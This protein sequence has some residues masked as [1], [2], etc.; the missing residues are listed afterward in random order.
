MSG[1]KGN[2]G[3]AHKKRKQ[4]SQNTHN[5]PTDIPQTPLPRRL[6]SANSG[7]EVAALQSATTPTGMGLTTIPEGNSAT[8][9]TPRGGEGTTQ[10]RQLQPSPAQRSADRNI[11][12]QQL[13]QAQLDDSDKAKD[14]AALD[15]TRIV[16]F[17]KI[18]DLDLD[19]EDDERTLRAKQIELLESK[20]LTAEIRSRREA[21]AHS[22]LER[23]H[24][25]QT[26]L[27]MRQLNATTES[28]H[29]K[30]PQNLTMKSAN[31]QDMAMV[32]A[33]LHKLNGESE[34]DRVNFLKQGAGDILLTREQEQMTWPK[35][36]HSVLKGM[37]QDYLQNLHELIIAPKS[38]A[39]MTMSDFMNLK[40]AASTAVTTYQWLLR[41]G[42]ESATGDADKMTARMIL[43]SLPE[44][45]RSQAKMQLAGRTDK[46]H[47]IAIITSC[48]PAT[49]GWLP[50]S[51]HYL[52]REKKKTYRLNV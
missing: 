40:H 38:R 44:D 2:N 19:E 29:Q 30:V 12:A 24:R 49:S 31:C 1:K 43:Y 35:L 33:H 11:E 32:A 22:T 7:G 6:R 9:T 39:R 10:Q 45:I 20:L 48:G 21:E 50:K 4:P 41:I 28:K 51:N 13:Q 25:A 17:G 52:Y 14:V 5:T 3:S 46:V 36:V 15:V 27:T 26:E 16:E 18:D 37:N 23:L 34:K 8:P 47:T 42:G